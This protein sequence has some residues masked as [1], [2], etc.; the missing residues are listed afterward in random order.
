MNGLSIREQEMM[1]LRTT[2]AYTKYK[3]IA[4]QNLAVRLLYN[5]RHNREIKR[6]ERGNKS[7]VIYIS[8]CGRNLEIEPAG[9]A[10]HFTCCT[11]FTFPPPLSLSLYPFY[12]SS[13]TYFCSSRKM[14]S[15]VDNIRKK[16]PLNCVIVIIR[17][18]TGKDI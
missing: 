2:S 13:A 15:G 5:E 12:S 1:R 11:N 4:P 8:R 9:C 10:L 7:N 16:L 18:L 17:N 6:L 14:G 3:F